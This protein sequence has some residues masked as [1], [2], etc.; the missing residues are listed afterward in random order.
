MGICYM[1]YDKSNL[2]VDSFICRGP[3]AN[4]FWVCRNLFLF[5]GMPRFDHKQGRESNKKEGKHG[6]G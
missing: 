2:Y 5:L 6:E 1:S 3:P 4:N